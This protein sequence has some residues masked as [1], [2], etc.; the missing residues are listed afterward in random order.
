[1]NIV[2]VGLGLQNC[3]FILSSVTISTRFGSKI[4]LACPDEVTTK[5]GIA[6]KPSDEQRPKNLVDN[7]DNGRLGGASTIFS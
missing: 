4:W 6:N 7:D 5:W 1:M 3:C 2:N